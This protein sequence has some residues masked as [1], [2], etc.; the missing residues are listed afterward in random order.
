MGMLLAVTAT[1]QKAFA[2]SLV[3]DIVLEANKG[4]FHVVFYDTK[5][6]VCDASGTIVFYKKV[7]RFRD[8]PRMEGRGV[9]Q[10][11]VMER[12]ETEDYE[13]LVRLAFSE[14]DFRKV[15]MAAGESGLALP[16]KLPG[17]KRDD[18]LKMEFGDI[19]KEVVVGY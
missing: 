4:G 7:V 1:A 17:V 18:Q 9:N 3:D 19:R 6:K 13:P 14:A 15:R 8:V 12:V 10:Q 5:R 2:G 11:I 16:V